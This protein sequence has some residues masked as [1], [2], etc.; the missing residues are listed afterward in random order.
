M[1]YKISKVLARL[2]RKGLFTIKIKVTS[3]GISGDLRKYFSLKSAGNQELTARTVCKGKTLITFE[4]YQKHHI[5][6]EGWDV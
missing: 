6:T 4:Q 5:C 2:N 1:T 3:G